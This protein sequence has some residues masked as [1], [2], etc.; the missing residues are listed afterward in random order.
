MAKTG[1]GRWHN[2]PK[3]GQRGF[4][5]TRD[6][7]DVT[8]EVPPRHLQCELEGCHDIA[9]QDPEFRASRPIKLCEY[10]ARLGDRMG[11]PYP[12]DIPW[13][14]FYRIRDAV[15]KQLNKVKA[16][17]VVTRAVYAVEKLPSKCYARAT[18]LEDASKQVPAYLAYGLSLRHRV[19]PRRFI[20]HH[21]TFSILIERELWKPQSGYPRH[22][23]KAWLRCVHR[24]LS[25]GKKAKR[26]EIGPYQ[27]GLLRKMIAPDLQV[28]V[29]RTD[30]A[31]READL[32]GRELLTKSQAAAWFQD[33]LA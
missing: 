32:D 20:D 1:L 26:A 18:E 3:P 7:Y 24:S 8:G 28:I 4:R 25:W 33:C 22:A 12:C 15:R 11:A 5:P 13:E 30:Y 6:H 21:V 29:G 16:S 23:D 2:V 17:P 27:A 19:E 31:L 9:L 14:D 10:H